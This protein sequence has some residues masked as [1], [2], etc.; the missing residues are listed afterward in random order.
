MEAF[1][2]LYKKNPRSG[3]ETGQ[4]FTQ[5]H[6]YTPPA[7]KSWRAEVRLQ[8]KLQANRGCV[9]LQRRG[10]RSNSGLE[11]LRRTRSFP[12]R[13]NSAGS[14]GTQRLLLKKRTVLHG[15][16]L[17]KCYSSRPYINIDPGGIAFLHGFV[18]QKKTVFF[19]RL[20]QCRHKKNS[21]SFAVRIKMRVYKQAWR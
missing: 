21:F 4:E 5:P 13:T 17:K 16:A 14:A 11:I 18:P 7:K 20:Y 15:F 9:T 19:Q 6:F 8:G 1:R 12:E 10:C 2:F 3:P